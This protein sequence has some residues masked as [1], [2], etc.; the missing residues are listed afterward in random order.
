MSGP[1]LRS[2]LDKILYSM[3]WFYVHKE[4]GVQC[5]VNCSPTVHE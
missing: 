2:S 1:K 3:F 4:S 5:K